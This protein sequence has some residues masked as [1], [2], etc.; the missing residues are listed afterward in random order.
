MPKYKTKRIILL[1]LFVCFNI[2]SSYKIFGN[3]G[4]LPG[5]NKNNHLSIEFLKEKIKYASSYEEVLKTIVS[6]YRK[7]NIFWKY[8]IYFPME[9]SICLK[10]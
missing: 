1:T 6:I 5:R 4:R 9:Y 2:L 3:I 10:K 7:L 8:V